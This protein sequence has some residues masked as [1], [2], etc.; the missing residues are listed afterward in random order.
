[1]ISWIYVL[2]PIQVRFISLLFIPLLAMLLLLCFFCKLS[3]PC[4]TAINNNGYMSRR[5][6]AGLG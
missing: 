2:F 6:R 3:T 5:I 1:M 4:C